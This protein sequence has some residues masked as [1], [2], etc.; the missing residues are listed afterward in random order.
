MIR[1]E[2]DGE[3][4]KRWINEKDEL[5]REDGPAID[6]YRGS[7]EWFKEGKRHRLDGAAIVHV[8]G[9][10][11][12]FKEG[13]RHRLDGPAVELYFNSSWFSKQWFIEGKQYSEEEFKKVSYA[14]L[15]GLERF[16]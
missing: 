6:N 8:N 3:G 13:K 10:E 16:L 1:C 11:M 5:H 15:N 2:I 12:W 9:S 4:T 14:I 7:K